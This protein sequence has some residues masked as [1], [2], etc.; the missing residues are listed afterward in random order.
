MNEGL[1]FLATKKQKV[2]DN[3][4][5]LQNIVA[6]D[7]FSNN[8]SKEVNTNYLDRLQGLRHRL[9]DNVFRILVL[10]EFSAGK[11]T[12]LNAI[13]AKKILP[14]ATTE[15]TAAIN[16]IKFGEIDKIEV[17]LIGTKD[18]VLI[19]NN[20]LLTYSTSLTSDSDEKSRTVETIFISTP[21]EYCKNGVEFIDT[22]GLNTVYEYHEKRTLEYLINGNAAIMI[23]DGTQF[24]TQSEIQYLDTFRQYLGKIFFVVNRVNQMPEDDNFYDNFDGFIKKLNKRFDTES[25][26]E[27]YPVDAFLGEKGD[28]KNSGIQTFLEKLNSFLASDE[29]FYQE[30]NPIILQTKSLA[31]EI[32]KNL[33]QISDLYQLNEASYDSKQLELSGKIP[34]ISQI[35]QQFERFAND[36]SNR[37]LDDFEVFSNECIE[38]KINYIQNSFSNIGS[39]F[40][41]D[42]I[43]KGLNVSREMVDMINQFDD[44]S[45]NELE[46]LLD[47][48][49]Y[50]YV[51]LIQ[52]NDM[53]DFLFQN[54]NEIISNNSTALVKSSQHA[55]V[56][57]QSDNRASLDSGMN[58][59]QKISTA[60]QL[61]GG[62]SL[63]L[64][65]IENVFTYFNNKSVKN[66]LLNFFS[67]GTI[68]EQD[69]QQAIGNVVRKM[70]SEI[71]NQVPR[72][73]KRF[74]D[75]IFEFRNHYS[76]KFSFL[77]VNIQN[78]INTLKHN[79]EL[80]IEAKRLKQLELAGLI[81][82]I[83]E[84]NSSLNPVSNN[85]DK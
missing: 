61:M 15:T 53:A 35:Q 1:Q 41:L 84:I 82:K 24:L 21:S 46:F 14:T 33:D 63:T 60:Y 17:Q 16:V 52:D 66:D 72:L 23:L 36:R 28:L 78:A 3:I 19:R 65:V 30:L 5:S 43:F 57:N 83:Q 39:G 34:K 59:S 50:Q 44:Y 6:S 18:R 26:Q 62:G 20:E 81:N 49:E 27:L 68:Y 80:E 56:A 51:T 37:I 11:S 75:Q 2:L 74:K 12:F 71:R 4:N 64:E 58:L 7:I 48:L 67:G 8:V 73:K 38:E 25:I 10:G 77:L 13:L 55:V 45:K 40:G 47:D 69:R 70:R 22:P 42:K 79:K 85:V 76:T 32:V 9:N 54:G 29:K 31:S